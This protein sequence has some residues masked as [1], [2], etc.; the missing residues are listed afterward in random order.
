MRCMWLYAAL[1]VMVAGCGDAGPTPTA[2]TATTTAS[3]TSPTVGDTTTTATP[4]PDVD[5]CVLVDASD[6][7][8]VLGS[9]ATADTTP[10]PD[11]GQVS[12][13][14][15]ITESEALLVVSVF[16]GRQFYGGDGFPGAEPLDV[17]D[18]GF[19]AVEPGFGG[20]ALQ[21]LK[22]DWVVDLAAAPFGVVDVEG[23]P[24]AMTRAA[25]QAADRLP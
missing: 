14:A 3:A 7:A 5:A 15:W 25:Q 22:G 17:G 16:E 1:L 20:V 8:S 21:F 6:A 11:F 2:T 10:V 4:R 18:E 19:I 13:C 24:V 23:L 9:E 12:I